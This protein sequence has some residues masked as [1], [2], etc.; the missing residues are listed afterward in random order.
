VGRAVVILVLSGCRIS[1]KVCNQIALKV[2]VSAQFPTDYLIHR[3]AYID[4]RPASF[5]VIHFFLVCENRS[6]IMAKAS[7]LALTSAI[8]QF[9][10]PSHGHWQ[11]A[12]KRLSG[13]EQSI[14]SSSTGSNRR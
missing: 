7:P 1:A 6:D 14:S 4:S 13:Q 11:S 8:R 3:S 2:I 12:E 10:E 5:T 9:G